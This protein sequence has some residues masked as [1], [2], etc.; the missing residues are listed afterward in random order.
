M[1]G[2]WE[3]AVVAIE[4][5]DDNEDEDG[6]GGGLQH[7]ADDAFRHIEGGC[8]SARAVVEGKLCD[9]RDG[10]SKSI[11]LCVL[12]WPFGPSTAWRAAAS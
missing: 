6:S 4:E 1:D 11:F 10:G 3:D 2:V 8:A 5:E 7:R 9:Y 12:C